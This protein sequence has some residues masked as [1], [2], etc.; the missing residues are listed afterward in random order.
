MKNLKRLT[1][2]ELKSIDGGL[3]ICPSPGT[4]CIAWCAWT[5]QQQLRCVN[6]ILDIDPCSC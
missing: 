2:R 5:P 3:M 1:K 4:T 6:M